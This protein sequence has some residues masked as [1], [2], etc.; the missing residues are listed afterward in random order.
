IT[1]PRCRSGRNLC[2][3]PGGTRNYIT[4][5]T[6]IRTME[7][8]MRP[9]R[10]A[11]EGE[12]RTQRPLRMKRKDLGRSRLLLVRGASEAALGARGSLRV[13]DTLRGGAVDSFDGSGNRRGRIARRD[14]G[15]GLLDQGA[16]GTFDAAVT[17]GASDALTIAFFCGGM[18]RH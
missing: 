6:Q 9:N 12:G 5:H 15:A 17:L 16:D 13:N 4:Q 7:K 10:V 1:T 2:L 11:R 3:R 18:I 14:R 8:A